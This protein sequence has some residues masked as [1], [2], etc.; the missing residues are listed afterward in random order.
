MVLD[1]VPGKAAPNRACKSRRTDAER[2]PTH[3]A[4]APEKD[5]LEGVA[6]PPL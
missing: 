3:G 5:A 1:L 6:A 4:A 2:R